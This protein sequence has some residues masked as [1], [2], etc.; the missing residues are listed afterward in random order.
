MPQVE[1]MREDNV[2]GGWTF[3][4]QVLDEMGRL[5]AHTVRLSWADYNHWSASGGDEP[6]QVAEAVIAFLLTI[7]PPNRLPF[8][9]DASL[10]RRLSREADERIPMLIRD[11]SM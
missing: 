6:A 10:A 1:I 7:A 4:A 2:P 9:F 8:S 11:G 3:D 5:R